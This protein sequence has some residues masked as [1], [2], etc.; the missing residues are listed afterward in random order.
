MEVPV[1]MK[2]VSCYINTVCIGKVGVTRQNDGGI[3][4]NACEC[5]TLKSIH[6]IVILIAKIHKQSVDH[7]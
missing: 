2:F 1:D 3:S 6:I 4:S 7:N 5:N